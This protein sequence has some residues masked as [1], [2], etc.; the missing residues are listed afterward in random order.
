M[1]ECLRSCEICEISPG[2]RF[3]MDCEQFFCEA[4]EMSH[5]KTKPCRNHVFEIA[6]DAKSAVKSSFCK[7]HEEKF[8]YFC[9]TCTLLICNICLPKTHKTHDFCLINDAASKLRS[10][11]GNEVQKAEN[12]IRIAKDKIESSRSIHK[13]FEDQADKAKRNIEE[14]VGVYVN[15]FNNTKNVYLSSIEQHKIKQS[16]QK[17]Q[18]ILNLANE[19]GRHGE[20][21]KKTKSL[22]DG[23]NNTLLLSSFSDMSGTLRSIRDVH[24]WTS[25]P[26]HVQFDP[27]SVKLEVDKLIGKINFLKPVIE[28][29]QV[30]D[31]VRLIKQGVRVRS[32][33]SDSYI[34]LSNQIG[35]V[36]NIREKT[37]YINFP[38][39]S[40][41]SCLH[42]DLQ[43]P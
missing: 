24:M 1:A 35:T 41:W 38:D 20:V 36:S 19:K 31:R 3:C 5:L 17:N 30:G 43:L 21:L 27:V 34:F 14:Q 26:S 6:D 22:I 42:S 9:N 32:Q 29:I 25:K 7:L 37:V 10:S 39:C 15:A 16:Q 33:H 2:I 11:F 28:N 23:Q 12:I 40:N 8:T 13:N 4:C 18:E